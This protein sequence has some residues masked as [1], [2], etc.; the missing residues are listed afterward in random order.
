[1]DQDRDTGSALYFIEIY[2]DKTLEN[3]GIE[4]PQ[5]ILY[6]VQCTVY[7]VHIRKMTWIGNYDL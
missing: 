6:S 3:I 1:M 5:T 2:Y 7:S 4:I